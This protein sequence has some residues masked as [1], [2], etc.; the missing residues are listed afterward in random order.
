KPLT[1]FDLQNALTAK[2][3]IEQT[4]VDTQLKSLAATEV[5]TDTLAA[6]VLLVEDNK[7]NHVVTAAFL[8]QLNVTF[9]IAENGAEAVETLN[10]NPANTY[11]LILMD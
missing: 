9:E 2:S 6:H 4:H 11:Q 1:P 7:I 8:K 10:Q 3:T 5:M